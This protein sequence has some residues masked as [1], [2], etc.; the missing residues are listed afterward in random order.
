MNPDMSFVRES[1]LGRL[2]SWEGWGLRESP[3][4][5]NSISQV[6]KVS[7][8]V[9]TCVYILGVGRNNGSARS[10]VWE[11][12]APSAFSLNPDNS[13]LTYMS[14][15]PFELPFQPD[16]MSLLVSKFMHG[17]FKRSAWDSSSPLSHPATISTGLQSKKLWGL[18]G[19]GV[20]C[21][22]G[23]LPPQGKPQQPR[24]LSQFLD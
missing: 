9:P 20:W 16:Q 2:A 4:R 1:H 17:P 23:H 10:F 21:G 14:L 11:T 18:L 6:A 22:A 13:V 7:D 15:V 24:Y 19:L 5:D 12:T 3:G 8:R